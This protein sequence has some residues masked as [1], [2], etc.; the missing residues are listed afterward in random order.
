LTRRRLLRIGAST[1][2]ALA[3][4]PARALTPE[5]P[6]SLGLQH[7][8][9]GESL[10]TV[11]WADGKYQPESLR[12]IDHLLR[13]HRSGSATS[14]DLGLLDLLYEL[15]TTVGSR[16][17]YEIVSGYRSPQ[18][19]EVL[20]R[21]DRGVARRSYHMKGMAVDLRLPGCELAVLRRAA[22]DLHRGG[23]GYY[24]DSDFVH[25]DTGRVRFW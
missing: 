2:L 9:T 21:Q 5:R 4:G 18:T 10:R 11:Y 13:D 3:A 25:V 12:E 15:Q 17:S 14:M 16:R 6:R 22:R 23:V 24:P 8:H 7:L 1:T 19:N 20:R